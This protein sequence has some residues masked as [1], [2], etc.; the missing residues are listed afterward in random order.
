[1]IE[2][3][4]IRA[5]HAGIMLVDDNLDELLAQM[6]SYVPHKNIFQ[7]KAEDL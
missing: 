5:Q 3:G 2:V 4:F 7:M 6:A 1:M